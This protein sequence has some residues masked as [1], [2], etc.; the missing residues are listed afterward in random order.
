MDDKEVKNIEDKKGR[1]MEDKDVTNMENNQVK[2][3]YTSRKM[4]WMKVKGGT[5]RTRI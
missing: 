5:W 1:N 3:M 4:I 2:Y